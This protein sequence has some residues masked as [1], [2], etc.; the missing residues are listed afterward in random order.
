M[1]RRIYIPLIIVVLG[2][3]A[4]IIIGNMRGASQLPE[5]KK[6]TDNFNIPVEVMVVSLGSQET[7]ITVNGSLVSSEEVE[8]RSEIAG[9]ITKINFKEG[10]F[11]R[12]GDLLVKI[13]DEDLKAQLSKAEFKLKLA[14]DKAKRQKQLAERDNTSK[15]NL[16]TALNDFY[17][18]QADIEYLKAQIK[19]TEIRAPFDGL[20]GLR[21]RS[22]GSYVTPEVKIASLYSVNP[23]KVDFNLPQKYSGLITIGQ[24]IDFK[25]PARGA[26]YSATIFAVEPK[27]DPESRTIMV[28]AQCNNSKGELRPGEYVEISIRSSGQADAIFVPSQAVVPD[29]E[30][31]IVYVA[32]GG[33]AV[34][35]RV[36]IGRRTE[37]TVEI[38]SGLAP[39]D[40]VITGGI[41]M[42]KPGAPIVATNK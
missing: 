3:V 8:L 34:A 40:S 38:V 16:E 25:L 9:K 1:K 11:A 35:T 15:E 36:E 21:Y 6:N 22:E 7:A 13:N 18:A 39:G 42:L 5:Q 29:V 10:G 32:R 24:N 27:V 28:R 20:I 12:K 19:K 4:Y 26:E 30:G 41:M 14:D 37:E 23:I 17:Q 33:K 2:I 31:K